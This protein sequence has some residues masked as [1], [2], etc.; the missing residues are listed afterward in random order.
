MPQNLPTVLVKKQCAYD[1]SCPIYYFPERAMNVHFTQICRA[2]VR[3]QGLLIS[4]G[5]I[6]RG[7]VTVLQLKIFV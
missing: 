3:P 2:Q 1:I 5:K 6:G 7:I 4:K